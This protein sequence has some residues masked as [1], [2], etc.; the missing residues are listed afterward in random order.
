ME[1]TLVDIIPP[2]LG[3]PRLSTRVDVRG[4]EALGEAKATGVANGWKRKGACA[5]QESHVSEEVRG[6]GRLGRV[7]YNMMS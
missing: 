7:S 4:F 3:T 1:I 2:E 6:F 5:F